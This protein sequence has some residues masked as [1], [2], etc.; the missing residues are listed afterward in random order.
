MKLSITKIAVVASALLLA[1]TALYFFVGVPRALSS[2]PSGLPAT[3]ATT[4][5][6]AVSTTQSL[7]IGTSSA[8]ASRV[9][10]TKASAIMLTFSDAQ[11]QV[12]TGTY[13]FVQAASTTVAYDSG[14]YGC[15]AVR[16]YSFA[17]DTITVT[18]T[19]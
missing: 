9:I 5:P 12:P 14:L 6:A 15:G 19:R 16:A 8:C 3:V 10:S 2:A 4:S 7:V 13:G 17:S 11:G 18:E 1:G